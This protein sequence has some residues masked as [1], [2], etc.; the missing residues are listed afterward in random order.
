MGDW[1]L[2][3]SILEEVHIHST[4]VGKI[5]LTI[6]FIFRMLVLGV[7]AED[8]WDDEQ[9]EFVCNT[10]QPGCKNVCYDQAFP[11]SLI[12]YW[13][14][15]I[16]FVS[17][18]SLVYM[19]HALYRLRTLE[20]ER[21]KKKACLKAELEGTDPIQEDHR[22]IERELRKLDEQKKVRKAPLR[23]SLLRTYVFHILTRSVVEVGFIIGQCALYGIRLSPLYKCER[24][25]CPNSIDCFVSRPTEKNIFMVFMLVIAGV[26][27]F[28]NLLEIFHLGVKKIKQSLYGYKY[29]D[30]D[31]VYRSKKNSMVQQVCVL[32]NSS[33]QR[34]M[35]L[36]HMTCSI[37]PD[38]QGETP[39]LNLPPMAPQN[40]E[41]SNSSNQQPAQSH[42]DIQ[43]L[44]QLGAVD[45]RYT[46]ESR[47]PS[48]SSDE[49][50]GPH[51]SGQPQ[52]A[53]PRPTLMAGHM[54]IPA[55]LKNPQRKQSRV[56]ICKELS[57]MSDS[58]ESDHYPTARKCSFMSRGM[59]EG[60]LATPFDSADSQS[61]TDNEAQHLNQGESPVMTPP[62]PAGGRRMSMS[63]ILELSSIMKK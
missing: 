23:G 53:G 34:L 57:D 51:G 17:S 4:I 44:Q 55:A 16:I 1:N 61:G 6:L 47:K 29:G 8:V 59:S 24:L 38:N 26:S 32:T 63:M 7:A 40:Q 43:G 21:H 42:A 41:Q 14:L 31:S 2:L 11:I 58:P 13:V 37:V 36:T 60:M 19:G 62:P 54:E 28:L 46:L 22:R 5:W 9:S 56:S 33:P 25:P 3:G 49:S 35:Q 15:Q 52:Y 12:R 48:C 27:L 10:E 18:P 39:P 20:K 30:D 50:N 45:R